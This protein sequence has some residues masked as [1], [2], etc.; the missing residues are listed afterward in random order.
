MGWSPID[1]Q[2]AKTT[3]CKVER[4]PARSTHVACVRGTGWSAVTAQPDPAPAYV[5][6]QRRP[7]RLTGPPRFIGVPGRTPTPRSTDADTCNADDRRHHRCPHDRRRPRHA[8]LRHADRLAVNHRGLGR[9]P[10]PARTKPRPRTPQA[11]DQRSANLSSSTSVIS[12]IGRAALCD[13]PIG[14]RSRREMYMVHRGAR[15][16]PM[17]MVWACARGLQGRFPTP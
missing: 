6:C 11:S 1:S 4:A 15:Q 12:R 8:A 10:R 16:H 2:I 5:L 3:P 17:K 9:T 13:V 7:T 14:H